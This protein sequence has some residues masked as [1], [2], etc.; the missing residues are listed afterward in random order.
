MTANQY[1]LLNKD[2]IIATF[3]LAPISAPGL[4]YLGG[5]MY[6]TV[7]IEVHNSSIYETVVGSQSL[8]DFLY[9]RKA[10]QHREHV[11]KLFSYLNLD[12]IRTFLD[13]TYGLSL[14]DTLWVKPL[15]S[16]V[17]WAQVNLYDHEFSE[18]IAQFALT[19]V[20][21]PSVQLAET[22][23]EFNTDGVLPKCWVRNK[24]DGTIKLVKGS[25]AYLGYHNA[26][27]EPCAEF[28][29]SQVA[30]QMRLCSYVEYDVVNINGS[31][32]SVCPLFT[33]SAQAYIAMARLLSA[34]GKR[35]IEYLKILDG[36]NFL[37]RYL[38]IVFFDCV[39]CNTDRHMGN[40][41]ILADTE[42][43]LPISMSPIFDNGMSLGCLWMPDNEKGIIAYTADDRPALMPNDNFIVTGRRLLNS[44][45]YAALERLKGW[46]I[47]KHPLYN[48]PDLKYEAMN[49]LLQHQVRGILG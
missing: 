19:G 3:A 13:I 21:L 17:T 28:Y 11:R 14:T 44:Q 30:K 46:T 12:H 36:Y 39:V 6:T 45:R 43:Y 49:E 15:S 33:S 47:P 40:F 18:D 24:A 32:S 48:W 23:P 5:G 10:P 34:G 2:C 1:L 38:D 22:S 7:D 42:T 26:G 37:E 31:I 27:F 16:P 35:G 8:D 20:G 9:S 41:G 4:E 29:A 25:T